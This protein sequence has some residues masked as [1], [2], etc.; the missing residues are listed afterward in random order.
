MRLLLCPAFTIGEAF[1]GVMWHGPFAA[2]ALAE[3]LFL[4]VG[5]AFRC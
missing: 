3:G 5:R 2:N 4:G 1:L